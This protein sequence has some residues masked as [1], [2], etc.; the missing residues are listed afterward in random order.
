MRLYAETKD[1]AEESHELAK[2]VFND[3]ETLESEVTSLDV[4]DVDTDDLRKEVNQINQTVSF[5]FIQIQIRLHLYKQV[6]L[7]LL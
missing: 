3:S 1:L 7:I 6:K 2:N 4:P 5:T